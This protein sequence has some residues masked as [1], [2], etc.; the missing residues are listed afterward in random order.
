MRLIL[1]LAFLPTCLAIGSAAARSSSSKTTTLP[2][3][4]TLSVDRDGSYRIATQ[5]PSWRFAG[6]V[7]HRLMRITVTGGRDSIGSYR[8]ISFSYQATAARRSGIRAYIE[9]PVVVFTTTYLATAPNSEPFPI[10]QVHPQLSYH[11]SYQDTAFG[12][13]LFNSTNAG[14]SPCLYFD[15]QAHTFLLSPAANFQVAD[16]VTNADDSIAA[17]IALSVTTL[18][19]GFTHRTMLVLGNGINATFQRWGKAMMALAGKRPV[20]NDFDVT[21]DRL[22]YWTDNGA[23]YYYNY[24]TAKGYEGTLQA[25][26]ADL[27]PTAYL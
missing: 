22:G 21:L 20:P 4:I 16:T 8:E 2:T 14:D 11:V 24:D 9:K 27:P 7:G 3:G 23:A 12:P 19:R 18:P 10:L 1:A 13:Y 5:A 25:V 26:K 17:G 15:T 6:T